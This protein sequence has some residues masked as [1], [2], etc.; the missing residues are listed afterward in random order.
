MVAALQTRFSFWTL[1]PDA[2]AAASAQGLLMRTVSSSL[3]VVFH[4]TVDGT[5]VQHCWVFSV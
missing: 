1:E 2:F 4:A 3:H 5:N